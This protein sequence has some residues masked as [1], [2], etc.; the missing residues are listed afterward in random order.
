VFNDVESNNNG[1]SRVVRLLVSVAKDV[2]TQ[3]IYALSRRDLRRFGIDL[4]S[5]FL[6]VAW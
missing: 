4:N 5:A 1:K 6:N 3:D 2:P